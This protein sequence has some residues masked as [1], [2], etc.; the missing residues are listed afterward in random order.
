MRCAVLRDATDG[1][2]RSR[3]LAVGWQARAEWKRDRYTLTDPV[4]R[5][6]LDLQDQPRG[7][8]G[9]LESDTQGGR[10]DGGVPTGRLSG[11]HVDTL[12]QLNLSIAVLIHDLG[13][14]AQR[15]LVDSSAGRHSDLSCDMDRS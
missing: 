4:F 3:L 14:D 12:A 11:N 5:F 9:I 10:I 6:C 13:A 15:R 2:R 1:S 8:V 7:R